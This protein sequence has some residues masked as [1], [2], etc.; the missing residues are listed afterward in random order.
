MRP[1]TRGE[2]ADAHRD[3]E[4]AMHAGHHGNR[5]R[6][7]AAAQAERPVDGLRTPS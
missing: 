1:G 5:P 4:A 3:L 6:P 2:S 7:V